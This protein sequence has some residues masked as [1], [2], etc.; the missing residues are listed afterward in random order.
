MKKNLTLN[1]VL[2]VVSFFTS[3]L[4][5]YFDSILTGIFSALAFVMLLVMTNH[6]N[7]EIVLTKFFHIKVEKY[8]KD[9][10]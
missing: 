2:T 4:A 3:L 1:A 10:P 5:F 6:Y 7:T 9:T 8:K